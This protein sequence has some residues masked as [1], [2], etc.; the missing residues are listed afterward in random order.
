M[1]SALSETTHRAEASD[2]GNACSYLRFAE[3]DR[4][5]AVLFDVDGTL[6]H[7]KPL[8]VR[9]AMELLG[10]PFASRSIRRAHR[11]WKIISSFRGFREELRALSDGYI[12]L[13]ELQYLAAANRLGVAVEEVRD[14]IRHWM[15]ERP[16]RH[17][18]GCM[19]VGLPQFL[20]DLRARN[21]KLGVFSDYPARE[22]LVALGVDDFIS[23]RLAATDSEINAFKPSPVGF[24]RACSLFEL[25]PS[26]VLY[27]GD[28]EDVDAVGAERAG[29]PCAILSGRARR[30]GS[31][32]PSR[33]KTFSSLA[34]LRPELERSGEDRKGSGIPP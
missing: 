15:F 9:M 33:F 3:H 10:L 29:M 23:F 19:R 25:P 14:V 13:E 5:G 31:A 22:K 2:S 7:Q 18:P 16:L 11:T 20:A 32:S 17:L 26:Q 34:E 27:V 8:R 30:D 6:Y 1:F 4:I 28:R 24:L 21:V 12:P